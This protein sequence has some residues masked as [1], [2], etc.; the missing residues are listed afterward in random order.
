MELN[1]WWRS[2]SARWGI[3]LPN[4]RKSAQRKEAPNRWYVYSTIKSLEKILIQFMHLLIAQI[5]Q[6]ESKSGWKCEWGW[7]VGRSSQ[8]LGRWD[9][10]CSWHATVNGRCHVF[11]GIWKLWRMRLGCH[12]N[13]EESLSAKGHRF[14]REMHQMGVKTPSDDSNTYCT[15]KVLLTRQVFEKRNFFYWNIY[16]INLIDL[17]W[18]EITTLILRHTS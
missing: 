9:Q 10:M 11:G 8:P 3:W 13:G 1:R 5:G 14:L 18:P 6:T 17:F 4:T 15:S 2:H 12:R 7:K 16:R